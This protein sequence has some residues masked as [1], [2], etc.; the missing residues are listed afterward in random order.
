M[1][2]PNLTIFKK[3]NLNFFFLSRR[4]NQNLIRS[5]ICDGKSKG[6]G[7]QSFSQFGASPKIAKNVFFGTSIW[8]A[9]APA[10][11]TAGRTAARQAETSREKLLASDDGKPDFSFWISGLQLWTSSSGESLHPP[12]SLPP[13]PNSLFQNTNFLKT[14]WSQLSRLYSSERKLFVWIFQKGQVFQSLEQ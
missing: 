2:I 1:I 9:R 3:Q 11:Q 4:R 13:P 5:K 12:P 7:S 8:P 10:R 6:K 14:F